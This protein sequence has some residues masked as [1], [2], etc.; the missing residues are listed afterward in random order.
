MPPSDMQ[1]ATIANLS[2]LKFGPLPGTPTCM[3]GAIQH[4]DPMAGPSVIVLKFEPGCSIPWHWHSANEQIIAV[5]GAS[6]FQMKGE[7]PRNVS[8]GGY[9][10][11]PAKHP[12]QASC[13]AGCTLYL[14]SDGPFDIHYVDQ[15][16]NEV[17]PE[18]ALAAIGE[19][20]TTVAQK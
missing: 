15:A 18:K 14:S 7:Q 6:R 4:G 13:A 8:A 16:G 11:G 9:V 20:V 1:H 17:S 12:H 10:F 2:D 5:S 3:T 19:H